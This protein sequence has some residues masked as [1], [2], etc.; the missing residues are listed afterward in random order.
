MSAKNISALPNQFNISKEG[1]VFPGCQR[2]RT[3]K[4]VPHGIRVW[5]NA[6]AG[7]V[8]SMERQC[9]LALRHSY[10]IPLASSKQK[11]KITTKAPANKS[12]LTI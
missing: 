6:H 9:L 10:L 4:G 12:T 8:F 1:P 3:L 5:Q 11:L 7:M 2:A